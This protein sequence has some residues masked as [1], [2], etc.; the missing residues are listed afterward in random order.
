MRQTNQDTPAGRIQPSQYDTILPPDARQE[1]LKPKRPAILHRPVYRNPV[2]DRSDLLKWAGS[3]AVVVILFFGT[4]A[5][6]IQR[7]APAT[8]QPDPVLEHSRQILN[9]PVHPTQPINQPPVEP[10]SQPPRLVWE[11]VRSE[12]YGPIWVQCDSATCVP[13]RG[14]MIVHDPAP[15]AQLVRTPVPRAQLISLPTP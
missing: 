13:A 4:F 5:N 11:W 9:Q 8:S 1:M 15:H 12:A 2:N 10:P 14:G 6:N 7:K 3:I